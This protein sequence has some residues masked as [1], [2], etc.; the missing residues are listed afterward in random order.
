[1]KE[2]NLNDYIRRALSKDG[3]RIDRNILE[4]MGF[5]GETN[6]GLCLVIKTYKESSI[7]AGNSTASKPIKV[8]KEAYVDWYM[9]S[10]WRGMIGLRWVCEDDGVL[11][12][13]LNTYR[14][15]TIEGKGIHRETETQYIDLKEILPFCGERERNILDDTHTLMCDIVDDNG[16]T[17]V[18]F[19]NFDED[20]ETPLRSFV[21]D[22]TNNKVVG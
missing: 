2:F 7:S 13:F 12:S 14:E 5:K 1:M 19:T 20:F 15:E 17:L 10:Y 22:I 8:T 6:F 9:M 16:R 11:M 21:Y 4:E 3:A 18:T